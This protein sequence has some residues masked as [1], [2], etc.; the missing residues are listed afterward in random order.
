MSDIH[1]IK[2]DILAIGGGAA[3][4]ALAAGAA[5]RGASVLLVDERP[6]LGGLLPQC[7][8]SGFGRGFYGEDLTGPEYC[9][10]EVRRF[11]ES[12]ADCILRAH[13]SEIRPDRT[14]LIASPEGLRLCSFEQCVLATGCR[15]NNIYSLPISGTR[16]R[17]V[18]TAGEAQEMMNLGHIKIGNRVVIL[19]SGDIGQI[20]ARRLVLTGSSVVA[21]VEMKDHLGGMRRNHIECVEKYEIPVVLRATVTEVHGYPDITAVTVSHLDTG[22][23]EVMECDALVTAMGLVPDTSVA[24]GLRRDGELPDWIHLCGNA[25]YVHEIVDGV[26]TDGL[27]IGR[28]LAVS[29]HSAQ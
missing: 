16:P 4:L 17:G 13:V 23:E 20:V 3:G 21:M 19:G 14:S 8:H 25:E 6:Y 11:T 12:G 9:E 28:E 7:I 10:R 2:T 15:E 1:K 29:V 5:S 27:R 26:T 24:D 18:Y 22:M